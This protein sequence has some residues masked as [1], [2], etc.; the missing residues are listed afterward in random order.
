MQDL[1][2]F[3]HWTADQEAEGVEGPE[4]CGWKFRVQI[5][6]ILFRPNQ[7]QLRKMGLYIGKIK[8]NTL[9]IHANPVNRRW[10]PREAC[11]KIEKIP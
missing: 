1:A 4:Y 2:P 11:A 10:F 8:I 3:A 7:Q 5:V 6:C 9:F